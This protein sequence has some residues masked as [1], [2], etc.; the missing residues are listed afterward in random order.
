[1]SIAYH[2]YIFCR[3]NCATE[4]AQQS[5]LPTAIFARGSTTAPACTATRPSASPA[6]WPLRPVA[7]LLL[8]ICKLFGNKLLLYGNQVAH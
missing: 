1:M 5:P 4:P 8:F 6:T 3:I 7:C 2:S